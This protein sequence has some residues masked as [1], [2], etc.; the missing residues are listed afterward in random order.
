M[1]DGKGWQLLFHEFS[2]KGYQYKIYSQD[3]EKNLQ[4]THES[5]LWTSL[6][7]QLLPVFQEMS[8][9]A[10]LGTVTQRVVLLKNK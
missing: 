5:K 10:L 1:L 3:I 8:P 4:I 9:S 7:L 2:F 6:N